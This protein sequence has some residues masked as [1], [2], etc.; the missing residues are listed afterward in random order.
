MSGY[1]IITK[2]LLNIL[3]RRDV[4]LRNEI[5]QNDL[6]LGAYLFHTVFLFDHIFEFHLKLLLHLAIL[7]ALLVVNYLSK[8]CRTEV[9]LESLDGALVY[10][11]EIL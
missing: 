6:A 2:G 8:S 5:P 1:K 7:V 9:L 10:R 11:E 4:I 3:L